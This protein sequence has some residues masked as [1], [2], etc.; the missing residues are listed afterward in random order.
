MLSVIAPHEDLDVA[1]SCSHLLYCHSS[2][3]RWGFQ[4]VI[5]VYGQAENGLFVWILTVVADVSEI[6][7]YA[8]LSYY[9]APLN[10]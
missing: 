10:T 5:K 7:L 1:Y 6:Q 4:G 2:C 3:H 9:L 8:Y